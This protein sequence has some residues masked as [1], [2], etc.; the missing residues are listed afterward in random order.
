MGTDTEKG[1]LVVADRVRRGQTIQF[2]VRDAASAGADLEALMAAVEPG[3]DGSASAGALL[4]SCN[5]RG[6]HMFPSANHD[7]E[8]VRAGLADG[9]AL[10]GFFANGEIGPVGGNNFLHGFTA[11]VAVFRARE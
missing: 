6:S 10:A 7:V 11:S 3:P 9:A 8:L 4:F 5:G 1:A 2:L